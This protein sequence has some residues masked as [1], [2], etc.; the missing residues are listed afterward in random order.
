MAK[1]FTI[2]T[3]APDTIKTDAKG[4]A[5][6]VYTVTN[7][8]SRP[9]RGM[10]KAVALDSTRQE[11]L[12]VTGEAD[13]DFAAGS[14]QQFVVTFDAPVAA[15]APGAPKPAGAAATPAPDATG[16]KYAF[17]LVVASATNPDEDFTEGQTIR[18]ETP[19]ARAAGPG[20]PFPKW[21]FIPIGILAL[22]II[23]VVI[24]LIAKGKSEPKP[25]QVADVA[26]VAEADAR[27]S[28]E[29]GCEAGNGC[30]VVTVSQVADNTVPKGKALG[31]D[32]VAGTEVAPGSAVTLLISSGPE[33]NPVETFK[34]PAVANVAQDN[35]KTSLEKGCKKQEG[36][37]QVE[38]SSVS[39]AKI[40]NGMAIRS[41]PDAG[42]EVEVGSKVT[43]FVSKGPDKV[44]LQNVANQTAEAAMDTLEK[45]CSP[46]PCLDVEVNRIADNNVAAGRVIRTQPIAGSVVNAG[47]KVMLFVSGGTD[48]VTIPVVF[49][50]PSFEARQMLA[51]ACRPTPCLQATVTNQN[52]DILPVGQ[53]IGTVPPRGSAVK[54]GSTIVLNISS[55]PEVKLVG[56]YTKM[57]EQAA[58]ARIVA[59]GFRVGAVKKIPMIFTSSVV[60]GQDPAPGSRRPKGTQINLTVVGK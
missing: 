2:T 6:A 38:V 27:T 24:W 39:D 28:L 12:G 52:H 5:E 60:T 26:G 29:T 4:H 10:A 25:I 42:A 48:Q 56:T 20:K 19:K 41:E 31:T 1:T 18:V 3:T 8:S 36:C 34:L 59:D 30:L 46:A 16:D 50:K 40:P 23:G 33:A 44:T 58:R 57:T 53:A 43:L 13:R 55:G 45:S 51:N 14:T 35:A 11:W 47:S 37:V 22:V 17:R 21:I 9:V 32:P 7:T 54:I 49:G 15:P